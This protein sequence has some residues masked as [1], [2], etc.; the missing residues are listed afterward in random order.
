MSQLNLSM[1]PAL[2]SWIETRIAEG[3]FSSA[4]DYVRHLIRRDLEAAQSETEWLR[5]LVAE[6]LASGVIDEEPEDVIEGIIASRRAKTHKA[7][8]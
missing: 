6:G 1:P 5:G 3:R 4:S 7:A 8:A 2:K